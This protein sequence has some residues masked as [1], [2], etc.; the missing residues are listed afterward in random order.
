MRQLQGNLL[1]TLIAPA[2]PELLLEGLNVDEV[3]SVLSDARVREERVAEALAVLGEELARDA[4][5]GQQDAQRRRLVAS[6]LRIVVVVEEDVGRVGRAGVPRV[7]RV[8]GL[9]VVPAR[10]HR[11]VE[12]PLLLPLGCGWEVSSS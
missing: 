1:H 12:Q 11:R 7:G 3:G 6:R 10:D 9:A 2:L 5:G 4:R 8:V